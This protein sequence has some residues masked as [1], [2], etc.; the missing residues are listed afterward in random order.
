[1]HRLVCVLLFFASFTVLNGQ[2]VSNP[3]DS[4]VSYFQ[5]DTTSGFGF[6]GTY[7]PPIFIQ[8][9]MEL[10]SFIRS[11]TFNKLRLQYGD[12]KAVDAIFI[13]AMKLTNNNTAMALLLATKACFDHRTVGLKV[14]VFALFFPLS[15]ES[16]EEF[17]S[18]VANLPRKL[19]TDTPR[20]K[21]GD[22]DKLQ[23]FFGS[24]FIAFAFESAEPAERTS[25]FVE[26]G[27]D[28]IIVDGTIDARDVRANRQGQRFGLALLEN[29]YRVPS[30]FISSRSQLPVTPDSSN[31]KRKN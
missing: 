19:Y 18:R 31:S 17:K 9:G 21:I 25:E 28:L 5:F 15:N 3:V 24:A 11:D 10:K 20:G 7:F 14:P 29:C 13:R 26:K 12:L 1:M 23:H 6:L 4:M 16:R 22:R 27:E 8:N 2:T 30:E